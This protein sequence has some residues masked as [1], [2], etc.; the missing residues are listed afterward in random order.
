M[1]RRRHAVL[2]LGLVLVLAFV[3]G[4]AWFVRRADAPPDA[5]PACDG[6]AALTGGA[7]RTEAA[8]RLLEEGHAER[9]LISGVGSET[10]LREV[11]RHAGIAAS[12]VTAPVTL[13][14]RAASTRGNAE[15]IA[16]W[17][18]RNG[19]RCLIVVTSGYHMP[20]ALLELGRMLPSVRLVSYPVAPDTA[21]G[22]G[23]RLLFLEYV[24]YLAAAAGLSRFAASDTPQH[25]GSLPSTT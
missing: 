9:L 10:G 15:E 21:H 20:R 19:M 11:E 25:A 2:G 24:K 18:E 12:S 8:F 16:R 22:R 1:K 6:I 13:G 17:A 23:W 4:F 7:R 14:H 5:L 3:A